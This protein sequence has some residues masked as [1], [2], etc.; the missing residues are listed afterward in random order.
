M[1]DSLSAYDSIIPQALLSAFA[2]LNISCIADLISIP[3]TALFRRLPKGCTSLHEVK[4]AIASVRNAMASR[5]YKADELCQELEEEE[6]GAERVMCGIGALDALLGGDF[7]RKGKGK[8]VEIA[9]DSGSGKTVL[10]LHIVLA[11][12]TA[13]PNASTLWLDTTGDFVPEQVVPLLEAHNDAC[14]RKGEVTVLERIHLHLAFQVNDAYSAL[15]SL[16]TTLAQ[17]TH[18][19]PR[20]VVVDT[21]TALIGPLLTAAS[22]E[23]TSRHAIMTD[24]MR[25]LRMLAQLHGLSVLVL[26]NSTRSL[27]NNPVSIFPNTVRKPALGPSFAFLSDVTLW[28]AL[29]PDK[30]ENREEH[31]DDCTE[32]RVAEVFRSKVSASGRWCSFWIRRGAVVAV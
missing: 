19:K 11:H 1:S 15:A 12:L 16:H 28:L 32:R 6:E 13:H 25:N 17:D 7:G 9:G 10:A 8:V 31:I 26:N 24:F 2:S 27:P 4:D 5:G 22:S 18:V 29:P 20:I 23:G 21:I 30:V 3:P 14:A